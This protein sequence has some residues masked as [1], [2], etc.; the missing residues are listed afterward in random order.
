[1]TIALQLRVTRERSRHFKTIA[2][3]RQ[4][5]KFLRLHEAKFKYESESSKLL[6]KIIKEKSCIKCGYQRPI[7]LHTSMLRKTKRRKKNA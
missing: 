6:E 2:A 7:P 3:F 5:R 4:A 1:M